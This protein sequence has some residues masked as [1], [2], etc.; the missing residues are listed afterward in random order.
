[1]NISSYLLLLYLTGTMHVL[2]MNEMNWW[3]MCNTQIFL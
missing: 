3:P 2:Q 1:M